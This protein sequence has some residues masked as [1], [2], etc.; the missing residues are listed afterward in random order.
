MPKSLTLIKAFAGR[1]RVTFARRSGVL[2][3]LNG[4]GILPDA[5]ATDWATAQRL[6][7]IDA[8]PPKPSIAHLAALPPDTGRGPPWQ[9]NS[10]TQGTARHREAIGP[11]STVQPGFNRN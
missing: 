4:I 11:P 3:S 5:V 9:C 6:P 10:N 2:Q 1:D 7:E 8:K